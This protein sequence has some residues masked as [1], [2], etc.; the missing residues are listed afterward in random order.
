[1]STLRS[2]VE[3]LATIVESDALAMT[4]QSLGQYRRDLLKVIRAALAQPE[5]A[6]PVIGSEWTPCVKLPIT[7]HVREQR[8]GEQHVSTREGI[9]PVK[10]D[11][12]IMRGV[13]GEEYPIGRELFEKTYR[14]G[15]HP[16][17]DEWRP[18]SEPPESP[19]HDYLLKK[20]AMVMPLFEEARDALTAISEQQRAV[21]CISPTLADRMDAAGTYSI[22]DWRDVTPPPEVTVLPDGSAFGMM[23]F[24]LPY[25]HWMYRD[26]EYLPGA[27]EPVDLPKPI[28]TH[29][30]REHVEAAVRYAVRGA[31]NCGKELDFD[32]DALVLTAVYALCGPYGGAS[33]RDIEPPTESPIAAKCQ[34]IE[35]SGEICGLTPPCPDCGSSLIDVADGSL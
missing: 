3:R 4:Y 13:A 26:R 23:S 21:R 16:P 17:R 12:L 1:M 28:L 10:P 29:A 9:T 33:L 25:D 15:A 14:I 7:V 27:D 5:S 32:P 19:P 11:D 18:A 35:G 24:P 22:D 20:L 30:L 6:G 2:E 34:R 8:P 31:T